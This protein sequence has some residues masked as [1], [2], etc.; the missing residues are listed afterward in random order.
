MTVLCAASIRYM[1]PVAPFHERTKHNGMTFGLSHAGYDVRIKQP[2]TLLPGAFALAST[3]EHFD[4]P[5]DVMAIVHDKSTW[6]R[7][8]LSVFNTVIEP[9]WN[10]WLTLELKNQGHETIEISKGDPI[11]QI[12]FH[13]L[14]MQTDGYAGKYQCQA[15]RP[16]PAILEHQP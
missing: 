11:A 6:A 4:M 7:R 8:G 10:G 12:V 9:G 1:L 14:D 2:F 15:N 13:R 3:I 5:N 16:V